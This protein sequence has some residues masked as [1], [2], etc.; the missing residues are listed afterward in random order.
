MLIVSIVA[1]Y[2]YIRRILIRPLGV[3]HR[4]TRELVQRKME[5]LENFRVD[6]H[7]GDE[8][9]ELSQAFQYMTVE[10]REYIRNLSYVT[11]EKE[12]IGAEL[13]VAAKIQTHMLPC[14]FPPFP[15]RHEFDIY[16]TMTPATEVGGDFYDFFLVDEDHLAM[17]IADVSGKG[18]PEA[19]DRDNALCGTD[20]MVA[21]LNTVPGADPE[22]LLG[23]VRE[24]LARFVGD[25][26]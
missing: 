1:Y 21:A 24:D 13:D 25:A 14:I 12:R 26:P 9:E 7:T 23:A 8:L 22:K 5:D 15:D 19:T 3:L 18:V 10:L 17:V 16:A 2:F 6:I 11:A 4:A 20:R